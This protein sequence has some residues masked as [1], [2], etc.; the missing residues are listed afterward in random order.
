MSVFS[1]PPHT[2]HGIPFSMPQARG[3]TK[4]ITSLSYLHFLLLLSSSINVYTQAAP[5]SHRIHH[6]LQGSV[7]GNSNHGLGHIQIA[8]NHAAQ[9]RRR[10]DPEALLQW[11]D[12]Q[13]KKMRSRH[14]GSKGKEDMSDIDRNSKRSEEDDLAKSPQIAKRQED[15]QGYAELHNLYSDTEVIM[16]L[17][18]SVRLSH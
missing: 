5:S 13:A 3:K 7:V 15:Q 12:S 10:R 6:P 18:Q 17:L 14:R 4:A 8:R 16:T 2:L 11:A 9:S 1:P